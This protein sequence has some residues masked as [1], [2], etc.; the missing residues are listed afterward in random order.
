LRV[1][2]VDFERQEV[3]VRNGKG[4]RDR[5]APLPASIMGDLRAWLDA[6]KRQHHRDLA[7][8]AGCVECPMLLG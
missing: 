2:D 1:K 3:L 6:V 8:G 5:R 7:E 4:G